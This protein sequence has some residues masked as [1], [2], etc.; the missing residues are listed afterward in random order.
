MNAC[1]YLI[2]DLPLPRAGFKGETFQTKAFEQTEKS[3]HIKAD[4][5]L[6]SQ[7]EKEPAFQDHFS[8]PLSFFT[9]FGPEYLVGHTQGWVEFRAHVE[10]GLVKAI[11]LVKLSRPYVG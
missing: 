4:G 10:Q 7:C 3:F 5:T 6:W 2:C 11:D 1:D 8:G 9:A